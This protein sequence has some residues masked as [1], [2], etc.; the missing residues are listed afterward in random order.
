MTPL[1]ELSAS[2]ERLVADTSPSVVSVEHARGQGSGLVIASDGYVVT[3]SHVVRH[4][5]EL[6]VGVG[7]GE[8]VPAEVVG[9]D[10]A[11]D[12]A[13]VRVAS[14]GLPSL[15]LLEERRLRVGQLVLAIGNPLRFDRS[16]SL[17][18]VSA[19]DRTLPAPRGRA[20]EGLVQTDA[21]INPGSSGGPLLDANGV[22]VG[23]TTAVIPMARGLGFAIPAHTVSWVVAMLLKQ[24]RIE[25]PR[26]GIAARG[27]DLTPRRAS[28]L[29]QPR[30]VEVLE[31]VSGE[32]ADRAG[33]RAGDLL[34]R[35]NGEPVG[36]VDDMV[37]KLVLSGGAPLSL[38]LVRG[39]QSLELDVLP[40]GEQRAA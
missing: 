9:D 29:G 21:A 31:V 23:I 36:S 3:N 26:I 4:A 22:A 15:P 40:R 32:A 13:V 20:L 11:S 12:L 38:E 19:I 16:V 14:N 1:A 37:R 30:A 24:G 25:R 39:R 10:P 27:I 8:H 17:G 28:E 34:L 35:A 5:G 7:P 33:V 6:S 18:I 2:I